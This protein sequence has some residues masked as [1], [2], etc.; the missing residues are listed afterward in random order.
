MSSS[1]PHAPLSPFARGIVYGMSLAGATLEKIA[2]TVRKTDGSHPT[3]QSVSSCI[4]LCKE[5]GGVKWDGDAA[6]LNGGGRPRETT[7][8]TDREIVKLVCKFRG[9][10]KVTVGFVKKKL[11]KTRRSSD[12]L[13]ERR[14]GD[15]GLKWL[16]RR[17][18]SLVPKKHKPSRI[19]WADW[20]G[21]NYKTL[22][23]DPG[24]RPKVS[25]P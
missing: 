20:V 9:S 15:A 25:S 3:Q 10:A 18:K 14:L 13:I 17:R 22:F 23:L 21:T 12:S 7:A 19:A 8:A 24:R 6:A 4:A 11:V 5:N 2:S 1:G 16:A